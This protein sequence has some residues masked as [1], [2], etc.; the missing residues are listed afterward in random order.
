MNSYEAY[1]FIE[2]IKG[3]P[4][5]NAKTAFLE[6]F[7]EDDFFKKIIEYTYNPFIT[8]GVKNI[9]ISGKGENDF[10]EATWDLLDKLRYREFT[11]N[12]ARDSIIQYTKG[13]NKESADLFNRILKKDLEA[14]FNVKSINKACH[15]LIPT[16]SY[17]RCS[18]PKDVRLEEWPWHSGIYL[19]EK[20]DGMFMNLTLHEENVSINSRK[21]QEYPFDWFVGL[22]IEAK[23][24]LEN[25]YQY[26]GELFV[27][28][29]DE[30][31]ER[32]KG[33]GIL[34]SVLKGGSFGF[35]QKPLYIVWDMIPLK[36]ALTGI[37]CTISY[38]QRL[39][40]L[41][42]LISQY[43]NSYIKVINNY[44]FDDLNIARQYT[45]KLIENGSEGAIL[46]RPDGIWKNGTSRDQV[47]LKAEKEAEMRIVSFLDGTG[48][49]KD[50]FGSLFCRSEDAIISCS[51]SGFTD[52]MRQEIWDNR[53][54]WLD[55]IITVRYHE[56][57]T[58]EKGEKSLFL[59]R[60]VE[61]RL[62]RERASYEKEFE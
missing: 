36:N 40:Q 46:K 20:L 62:D 37:P 1:Q 56:Q 2:I 13:L 44:M 4:S 29:G 48:K 53:E 18:L 58:N 6:E 60:F 14:G 28:D 22:A 49:N 17:M 9:E 8:F 32:K 23:L 35:N 30:I 45:N 55:E 7:L 41:N 50:T 51:V 19:Q 25:N 54:D 3:E 59:P 57:I 52:D 16:F 12:L 33:N 31:L 42:E 11:G 47:K 26:H 21:G 5:I 39:F 10:C 38:D 24:N 27:I 43:S 15:N 61:R 34:N